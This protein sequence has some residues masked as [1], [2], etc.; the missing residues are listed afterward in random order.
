ML[1]ELEEAIANVFSTIYQCSWLTR[2]VPEDWR[3]ASVTPIYKKGH[4]KDPG[5]YRLA[6]CLVDEGKAVD[7]VYLDFSKAFE[8]PIVFS[9]RSWQPVTWAGTLCW[10]KN[11]LDGW[12]QRAIVNGVKSSW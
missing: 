9:L 8:S 1:R 12:V 3:L 7:V 11:W 6:T 10:V 4:K 2:E 5:N